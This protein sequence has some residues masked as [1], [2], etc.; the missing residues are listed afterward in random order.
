MIGPDFPAVLSAAARGD[1]RAFWLLW[2]DLQP[3][4][5]AEIRALPVSWRFGAA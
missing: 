5:G 1:E 2:Q 4:W 3:P